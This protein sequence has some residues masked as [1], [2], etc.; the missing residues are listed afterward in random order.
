MNSPAKNTPLSDH[1]F[2]LYYNHYRKP[3]NDDNWDSPPPATKFRDLLKTPQQQKGDWIYPDARNFF[4]TR[5]ADDAIW[6]AG[7]LQLGEDLHPHIRNALGEEDKDHPAGERQEVDARIFQLTEKA[8]RFINGKCLCNPENLDLAQKKPKTL[9]I[10]FSPA[11]HNRLQQQC[12]DNVCNA[13]L[14]IESLRA[15]CFRTGWIILVAELSIVLDAQTAVTPAWLEETLASLSKIND[16]SW[17]DPSQDEIHE[18]PKFSLGQLVQGLAGI[19]N[20][21]SLGKRVY[22][23]C[24]L[25]FDHFPDPEKLNLWL[26]RLSRHYTSAYNLVEN[27]SNLLDVKDFNTVGHR[28]SL[29]GSCSYCIAEDIPSN[30]HLKKYLINSFKPNYLPITL[31]AVHEYTHLVELTNSSSF[32]PSLKGKKLDDLNKLTEL[33]DAILH[34]R[35]CFRYSMVSRISMHNQVNQALRTVMGLDNML[36]ELDNDTSEINAFLEQR[37]NEQ[38]N[39]QFYWVSML[40]AGLVTL[41]SSYQTLALFLPKALS[42]LGSDCEPWLV[43]TILS[44]LFALLAVRLVWL[45]LGKPK[46]K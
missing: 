9:G 13:I 45:K 44:T 31:L 32:W 2:F 39:R 42:K 19:I 38:L 21:K 6:E 30:Q 26:T 36:N 14:K 22:S 27:P 4:E 8:Q 28:Y 23:A 46:D 5:Y 11:A 16:L 15:V 24:Y 33:R 17:N 35:L 1:R 41:T 40:A 43:N 12:G 7:K 25:Q 18:M 37:N 34:F 3:T 10:N 20:H 29:E